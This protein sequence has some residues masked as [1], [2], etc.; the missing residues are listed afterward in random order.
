MHR[1]QR[2]EVPVNT[3]RNLNFVQL[4]KLVIDPSLDRRTRI[5]AQLEE[6]K[7]LLKDP[8]FMRSIRSWVKDEEGE[9]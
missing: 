5:V 3:H 4:P 2:K 6:Q 7:S 1:L 8:S 9:K